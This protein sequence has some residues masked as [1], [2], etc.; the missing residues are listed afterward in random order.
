MIC[1]H[2]RT[3]GFEGVKK[4]SAEQSVARATKPSSSVRRRFA[5]ARN[6]GVCSDAV[7]QSYRV[8][9]KTRRRTEEMD[10]GFF[11]PS[12]SFDL[13]VV[14]RAKRSRAWDQEEIFQKWKKAWSICSFSDQFV[15]LPLP[16]PYTYSYTMANWE[17]MWKN[18]EDASQLL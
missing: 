4:K 10:L 7:S 1:K 15:P 3:G 2:N 18:G 11:P 16:P 14:A 12:T 8:E 5:H 13:F 9:R 17:R 6:A